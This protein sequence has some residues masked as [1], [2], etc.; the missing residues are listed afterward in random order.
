MTVSFISAIGHQ[1]RTSTQKSYPDFSLG[2]ASNSGTQFRSTSTAIFSSIRAKQT[3][4]R[5]YKNKT[6][7][8]IHL[9]GRS[10]MMRSGGLW[11]RRA[12]I[13]ASDEFFDLHGTAFTN[14]YQTT[15]FIVTVSDRSSN[16]CPLHQNYII[17]GN[18]RASQMPQFSVYFLVWV[19]L[20]KKLHRYTNQ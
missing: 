9:R 13:Q 14:S 16:S 4:H 20:S 10:W 15:Q 18:P 2:G 7:D 12:I 6:Y 11:S 8:L 17:G 3:C 1:K 5:L 19:R